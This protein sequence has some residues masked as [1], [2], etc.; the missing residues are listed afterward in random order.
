MNLS[1]LFAKTSKDSQSDASSKNADLLVRAGFI[2]KTMAGVY[3]YLPLGLRVLKNIEQ[4]VREEMDAIGGQEILMSAL[5][6]KDYWEKT[7]RW[8]TL[9][10]LFRLPA[11]N[12]TEY[13]LNPTHEEVVTPIVK[14]F[15]NSYRNMPFAAYQIQTKFRNELRAKSGILR[16]REFLMKDL[17]SFH[18]SQEDLDRYYE[19]VQAAYMRVFERMGL[20]ELTYLTYASGGSFSQYSHEYQ[21][22]LPNG[23]DVVY[24]SVEAEKK[25]QR[26]AINKEIYEDGVTVC[27]LTGG[28]EFREEKGTEAGNIFKLG[29]KFSSAFGLQFTGSDGQLKDVIMGCYG[30]GISRL[31]GIVAEAMSD[32]AG[33]VW[34]EA[35]APAHV[36]IV[37]IC[38]TTDD[39]A[40]VKARELEKALLARG[41][42]TIFDDR[43]DGSVGS[44]L[45]DADLFGL[46]VR[47]VV[48]PKTLAEG[49]VE[50]KN[51][52][53][54]EVVMMKLDEC[55]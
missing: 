47:I 36:H 6:P 32:D 54:G 17:Y 34:P 5:S 18:A 10:V 33:L 3:S 27:P 13:A 53:T 4:I 23:E 30:I 12:D 52:K 26:I 37:P 40:F 41:K 49:N 35:I 43:L 39:G 16:G 48:S 21:I 25:G 8:E 11:A 31:M 15:I 22:L 46:P 45:A 29:N 44:R 50:V 38:K 9:D 19:I 55:T 20:G 1:Q 24:V 51:R 7:G 2:S 28:K 14:Q 42:K